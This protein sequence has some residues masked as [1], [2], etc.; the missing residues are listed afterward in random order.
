LFLLALMLALP[1]GLLAQQFEPI[2]NLYFTRPLNSPDPLPQVLP[3]ASTTA[4]NFNFSV[5]PTTLTPSGGTWLST[6]PTGSVCCSTPRGISV[7]VTTNVAMTQGTYTGQVVFTANNVT[8]VTVMVTLVIAP[9]TATF[10]DNTP[11]QVSFSM[12]PGGQPPPQV[13]QIRN[14]GAGTLSWTLTATTFNSQNWISVSVMSGTAPSLITVGIVIANLPGGGAT[15]GTYGG[16]LQFSTAGGASIVTVPVGLTVSTN[17]MPQVNALSFSKPYEGNN[18]LPQTV[19]IANGTGT[20]FDFSV[21]TSTAAGSSG[22]TWLSASPTG[23]VCCQSPRAVTITPAPIITLAAGTYTGQVL[24]DNGS[25]LM[26]IPVYLNIGL[27]STAFFD[28]VA[29]QLSFFMQK[30]ATNAPPN[31]LIQIRNAGTG[32]L[33]WT[34]TPTT[35][36]SANWLTVSD[37]GDTAPSQVSVGIVPAN[38]PSGAVNAGVYTA[39]LLF[40]SGN[41]SVTVP[42]TVQVGPSFEQVNGISFTMLRNGPDPLPQNITMVSTGSVFDFSVDY[43]TASGGNWLSVTPSGS[44]CCQTPRSLEVSVTAPVTMP[45]GIYTAQVVVYS[46]STAV[47]VPVTLTVATAANPYFD[48]LPGEM[49]FSMQTP[50]PPQQAQPPSNQ[51]FQIRNAGSGTLNWTLTPTTS[52]GGNW[53][54]VSATNGT[55]P[56]IITVGI[57]PTSLPGGGLNAGVFVGQLLL[58]AGQMSITIPVSVDIGT[59]VFGQLNGIDF[60]MPQTG[61]NPLPQVFTVTSTGTAFDFSVVASTATGGSWMTVSP[62]GSVCCQTPRTVTVSV[63]APPTLAAGIYTGQVSIYSSGVSQTVPVTLTVAAAGTAFFDNV[64]GA[65]SYSQA[66]QTGTQIVNPPSQNV[67][68]RNAGT[69]TLSWTAQTFTSDGGNWLTVSAP[70]G[71]APSLVSIGIITANLQNQGLEPGLFTGQ[72]LFLSGDNSSV[73]VPVSVR[74]GGNGFLQTNGLNFT[75]PLAGANPLPQV[76]NAISIGT[77]FD[78]SMSAATG[79]GGSW[80]TV[81]PT[82]VVCCQTPD[83]IVVTVSA[84]AGLAAGSYTGEVIVDAGT[85]VMVIPVTLTVAPLSSPFFDNVQGQMSFFAAA[86]VPATTP[87]SQSMLIQNFGT[88]SLAW[89]VTP[90]TADSGNWL[91]PSATTGTAP[92]N[93]TVSINPQNLPNQGLVAGQFSGQLLFQA[94]GST[95]TVPVSVQLGANIFTQTAGLNF[96]MSYGGNSPVSQTLNVT[97]SGTNFDT[98]NIEASGNGGNWLTVAPI[99]ID[100]CQTTEKITVSVNGAPGTPATPVPAG[101][102][103]GEAVFNSGHSAMVVPVTLTVAGTGAKWSIN[104]KHTGNFAAGQTNATYTVTVSNQTGAG[105]GPTSGLATVTET[106]P[107]GMTLVSMAG[108]NWACPPNQ[109]T[110]TRQDPL[111]M[112][113]SYDPITVTVNV[114]NVSATLTNQVSVSGGGA[115]A[116]ANASDPTIIVTPCDVNQQGSTTAADVQALINQALGSAAPANDLNNDGV[117]NV[118]DIQLVIDAVLNFGCQAM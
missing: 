53:L 68:I 82:G 92:S 103:L 87:A 79:N 50:T 52:D 28:D 16:Q 96:S 91:I 47:T 80:M 6:S 44:V 51:V 56:E 97:S 72:V 19:T 13:L 58:Q 77:A 104:K 34:L 112:G 66:V 30:G 107:T 8:T 27:T 115:V 39:N 45:A 90:V 61:A 101:I 3:I 14:A 114:P 69:G 75:M 37:L 59:T 38:L 21:S 60:T 89:T 54:T 11:G 18:P 70:N 33:N 81:S 116:A 78:F 7:I 5:T 15:A 20:A 24:A 106:V 55:A 25:Q 57:V 113:Q 43:S 35:F 22:G 62:T 1:G 84:P 65:L 31:Q 111:G 94:S 95:V 118:V 83:V 86:T 73:T 99:G 36:N 32:T 40:Q 64:P 76:V 12:Q 85:S 63:N 48:N 98:T 49:T 88:G 108:N 109:N 105:I 110:C 74:V 2:Q 117:V 93:I 9:P 29:G 42:I 100:C 41:S 17:A 23:S 46:S 102:H 26:V 67:Q 71:T 10:F 4:S